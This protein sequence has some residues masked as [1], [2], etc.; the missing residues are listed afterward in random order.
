MKI[1][2][3]GLDQKALAANSATAQRI[4]TYRQA[5]E[6]YELVVID[7]S[8]FKPL[9]LSKALWVAAKVLK[10]EKF[11]VLTVQDP[12]FVG[13][14]GVLLTKIFRVGLEIQVH[15]FE[16]FNFFRRLVAGFVL[17][18]ADAIRTVSSRLKKEITEEF[19]V[20]ERKITVAHVFV[21]AL[22]LPF[23]K[24]TTADKPFVFL[25]VGR[26]VPIKNFEMQIKA[27]SQLSS[28]DRVEL[29]I[30]GE[31]PEK[32]RL[33]KLAESL[34]LGDKIKFLGWVE[35]VGGFYNQADAFLLTSF[36][37][38]WPLVVAE[39]SA[40]GLPIIMTDVGSAGEFIKNGENGLVV[41]VNDVE[42]LKVAMEKIFN[43]SELRNKL[44]E[45]A[46]QASLDLPN[47]EEIIALYKKSWQLAADNA[48]K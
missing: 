24:E 41:P 18:Q 35:Q 32:T 23:K 11:D 31:G 44:G 5:V 3:I 10:Q 36:A 27:F 34:E 39:A 43:N 37:E 25:S 7:R 30:A 8:L 22:T 33:K 4:A 21:K 29:W 9:A 12:Y 19:R 48:R 46:R 14:A 40:A 16:K 47:Q 1:L 13:A 20:P 17:W 42:T 26:L 28:N 38:G 2:N 6:K 45:A 15:G